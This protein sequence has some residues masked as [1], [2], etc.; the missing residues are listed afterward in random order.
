MQFIIFYL[1]FFILYSGFEGSRFMGQCFQL[2][3]WTA[4]L[5]LFPTWENS[6]NFWKLEPQIIPDKNMPE[7]LLKKHF[8]LFYLNLRNRKR[9]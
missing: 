1:H 7:I 3:L 4:T 6:T 5:V 2:V 9:Y 8:S